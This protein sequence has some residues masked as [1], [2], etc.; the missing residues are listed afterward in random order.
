MKTKIKHLTALSLLIIA[1]SCFSCV[2]K[3]DISGMPEICFT[4]EVLPIFQNNCTM[5]GCHDGTGESDLSLRTFSQISEG[6]VP[7]NPGASEIYKAITSQWEERMP[8]NQPLSADNR[9]I[10]R[11]WIEQG[12]MQTV[13]LNTAKK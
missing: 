3:P 9:T 11:V 10:I 4:G 12:A 1:V 7:G 6:I 5:Q 13:C 2:H 8:P